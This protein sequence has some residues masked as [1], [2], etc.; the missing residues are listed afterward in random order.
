MK[1]NVVKGVLLFFA[2]LTGS[3]VAT[4][5]IIFWTTGAMQTEATP[6]PA[7]PDPVPSESTITDAGSYESYIAG[8]GPATSAPLPPSM[9]AGGHDAGIVTGAKS[10]SN[11]NTSLSDGTDTGTLR[12]IPGEQGVQRSTD[13]VTYQGLGVLTI[14]VP[15]Q[16]VVHKYERVRIP[17]SAPDG[18]EYMFDQYQ[19]KEKTIHIRLD[20]SET[21]TFTPGKE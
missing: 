2:I 20:V 4:F 10:Y 14:N 12:I 7:A 9:T 3:I 8:T 1:T 11:I 21:A 17:Q 16:L 6:L 18:N 19:V 5:V 15:G 13:P